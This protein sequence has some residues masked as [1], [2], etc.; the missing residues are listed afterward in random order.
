[1]KT[2][3]RLTCAE[4]LAE[5][6]A[7]GKIEE[8]VQLCMSGACAKD[9]VCQ[10]YLGWFYSQDRRYWES[11]GFYLLAA[12]QGDNAASFECQQVVGLIEETEGIGRVTDAFQGEGYS[13]FIFCQKY[14]RKY[15]YLTG[16]VEKNLFWSKKIAERGGGDD[17]IYVGNIFRAKGDLESAMKYYSLALDA[18]FFRAGHL[19]GDVYSKKNGSHADLNVLEKYY[20]SSARSGFLVG[21]L[22]LLHLRRRQKKINIIFFAWKIFALL[23]NIIFLKMRDSSDQ[24]LFDLTHY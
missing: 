18:G 17:I 7:G 23:I 13:N 11:L 10:R 24:N 21:K 22:R 16:D 1:M 9:S 3:R 5:L 2:N 4:M 12:E 6:D 8:A 20:K 19:L 14:L 15:F